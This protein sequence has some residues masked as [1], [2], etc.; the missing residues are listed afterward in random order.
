MAL[1]GATKHVLGW[2]APYWRQR[3]KGISWVML[4]TVVSIALST[5]YPIIFK[6]VIDSLSAGSSTTEVQFYVW[7]ILVVGLA[8]TLTRWILPSS[9][10]IMNLI[11]GMDIKLF[12]FENLLRK[13][14]AFFNEF[15]SGDL[16]TRFSD[17]IDG[18]VK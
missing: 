5:T 15:R 18:D 1:L 4:I 9:R 11:L 14:P 3:W 2:F 13:D 17:D 10:Y 8:R 12:H 16:I 6:Y 7:L